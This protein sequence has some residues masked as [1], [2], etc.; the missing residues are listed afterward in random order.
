MTQISR[1]IPDFSEWPAGVQ[2]I[3]CARNS[4]IIGRK[5]MDYVKEILGFAAGTIAVV[6]GALKMVFSAQE[7][8]LTAAQEALKEQ[9]DARLTSLERSLD[10]HQQ[11][12]D[13][14]RKELARYKL[15]V[16]MLEQQ[17]QINGIDPVAVIGGRDD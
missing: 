13:Q 9:H 4:L 16:K 11:E 14:L 15:H 2:V 17:L 12:I 10:E 7:R 8:R 5:A 6:L 3:E 1:H